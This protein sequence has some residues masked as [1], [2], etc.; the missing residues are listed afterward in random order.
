MKF[1]KGGE[2]KKT[3]SIDMMLSEGE[4][5][6]KKGNL[7]SAYF[8]YKALVDIKPECKACRLHM[9]KVLVALEDAGIKISVEKVQ[10]KIEFKNE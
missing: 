1:F 2:N 7:V 8:L 5:L 6:E 3:D 4:K 10:E 9:G